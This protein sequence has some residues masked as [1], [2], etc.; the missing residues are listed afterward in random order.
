MIDHHVNSL[1]TLQQTN[2][3]KPCKNCDKITVKEMG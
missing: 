3:K 1:S 2:S